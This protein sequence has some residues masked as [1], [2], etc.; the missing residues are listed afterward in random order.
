L[1]LINGRSLLTGLI[2][3]MFNTQQ[4]SQPALVINMRR[5]WLKLH[6]WIALGLGWLLALVALAGAILVIAPPLDR[7]SHPQ[8]FKAEPVASSA[9]P[10][11]LESIRERL[12]AAFGSKASFTLRPPRAPD[13]T[14]WVTVR[15]A[16]W[17][18]TVYLNPATG[19]EQ[20]RR[21]EYEGVVNLLFKFHSALLLQD[22]GKAILASIA[23]V[24]LLLLI[25]GLVLWWPKRW[26]PAL[27]IELRKGLLRGL[28]DM[29][30]TGGAVLGLL[31]AVSVATGA[32]MAWRPIS[33]FVTTLTGEKPVKPPKIPKG[34][35][36]QAPAVSLD[37]LVTRAQARF[38]EGSVSNIQ[39]PADADRPIRIRMRLP[40][41]PHPNG[42][43]S[44]WMHPKTGAEL[45]LNRWNELDAG[46]RAFS[47]VY[48]L[49]TGE[50][51]GL[52][53][54]AVTFISGLAL[55]MLGISGIWLWMRRRA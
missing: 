42:L 49:H 1:S 30:R 3:S 46:A 27:T 45:A 23:L 20:G 54:K 43:T 37:E 32:Y 38:P 19:H 22:T 35:T 7:L 50:L 16:P 13:Q 41:D 28:F 39:I 55:A 6:R 29:H 18:G 11:T 25:S 9:A 34:E 17:S 15:G 40:D 21:G 26:T 31:I 12:T 2:V 14:L 44:V 4:Q 10:P 53:L 33:E 48:P 5:I 51:G 36:S 52:A 8:L 24:Y 47:F